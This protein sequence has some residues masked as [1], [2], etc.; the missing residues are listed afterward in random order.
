V[1]LIYSNRFFFRG[2]LHA[3]RKQENMMKRFSEIVWCAAIFGLAACDAGELPEGEEGILIDSTARE[4]QGWRNDQNGIL[5]PPEGPWG[6]WR[7]DV[8]C[9]D[10][11]W[12]VGYQMRVESSQGG[13][14]SG[15]N[16]D[17]SLN[18]TRLL[19]RHPINGA[20]EWITPYDGLWGT[21]R[22][23]SSCPG[24]GNHLTG[25]RL[26]LEGSQGGDD[27]TAANDLEFAC[28]R[29]GTIHAP[30][31]HAWGSWGSWYYCPNNT[32]ICGLDIKFEGSQSGGDDTAMNGIELA[33]CNLP[34]AVCGDGTCDSTTENPT[35][36]SSDCGFCGNGLCS[37]YETANTCV[38]DCGYC[39]DGICYNE[40]NCYSD[41]GWGTPPPPP[42]PCYPNPEG[43]STQ[44]VAEPCP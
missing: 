37:V 35:S 7:Q 25:V 6:S 19:C 32:A 39:G 26:R 31:G 38:Q 10:G 44:R 36:C 22:S 28:A 4:I 21:W 43:V 14:L 5:L 12:A 34:S 29:G 33:C 24:L 27:D 9:T 41:C 18:S 1:S 8:Y 42:D 15:G 23:A 3:R 11:M 2:R 17:T 20:S 16:D 40:F 30:G 13:G